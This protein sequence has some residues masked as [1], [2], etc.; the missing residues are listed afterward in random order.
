MQDI[1]VRVIG[2][3]ENA[4]AVFDISGKIKSGVTVSAIIDNILHRV[5]KS[6]DTMTGPLNMSTNKINDLGPQESTKDA[7]T[8]NMSTI[9]ISH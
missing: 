3:N 2:V 4:V 6:G 5:L 7:V 1:N 9:N 8:K